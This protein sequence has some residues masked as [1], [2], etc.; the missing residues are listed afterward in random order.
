MLRLYTPQTLRMFV[1]AGL[2]LAV[3]LL[4]WLR[5]RGGHRAFWLNGIVI[6]AGIDLFI[7]GMRFNPSVDPPQIYPPT[8]AVEFLQKQSGIYRV[9]GLDLAFM[10]NSAMVFGLSDVRGYDAV[11]PWRQA[12][13]FD[14]MEGT[15]RVGHYGLL[16]SAE[17]RLLDLMNVTYMVA[18]EALGGRWEL[19]FQEPDS[20]IRV[21]RNHS[22]L[23]RAFLVYEAEDVDAS[24]AALTRL[25]DPDFDFR[26]TVLLE[27]RSMASPAAANTKNTTPSAAGSA[28][29]HSYEAERVE[30]E[31]E[32]PA[33]AWLV[34]S[35]S[36]MPGWQARIDDQPATLYIADYAF[37]AVRV[38]E[39]RHRVT[40][41]YRPDG[42]RWGAA[43]SG[44]TVVLLAGGA[45]GWWLF[46]RR[47][48]RTKAARDWMDEAATAVER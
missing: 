26:R 30:L 10:P 27:G 38:P 5:R 14:A 35:D 11:V 31:T 13:L 2:A 15:T 25:L 39:G 42:Y 33:D 22:V 9:G 20:P 8:P 34:L 48:R 44:A 36:Y 24:G 43:I 28:T 3:G 1:P 47:R 19:A 37:R 4:V 40:F 29:F 32:S 46:A 17:S 41:T 21:Y 7:F 23:P 45:L 16:R 18:D 6:L 12:T